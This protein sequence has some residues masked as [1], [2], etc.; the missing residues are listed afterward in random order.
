M[1]GGGQGGA[2]AGG[3]AGAQAAAS[4]EEKPAEKAKPADKTH[5]DIELTEFDPATKI[6]LIKEVRAIFRLG[7]K[8]A[9]ETVE[10][11]P[12][13]LKKDLIKD[14]AEAMKEKLE[15][16]GGKIRLV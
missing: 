7:L 15:S 2:P 12:C 14:E 4:A 11:A 3:N 9:K 6:K 16:L 10:K 13:W 1:G 5:Y 8:E